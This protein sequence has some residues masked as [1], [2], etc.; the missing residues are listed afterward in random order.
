MCW[1]EINSIF[2]GKKFIFIPM[3]ESFVWLLVFW[4]LSPYLFRIENSLLS[5]K[6][7]KGAQ[8]WPTKYH[9]A[10]PW[11]DNQQSLL[12]DLYVLDNFC[13]PITFLVNSRSSSKTQPNCHLLYENVSTASRKTLGPSKTLIPLWPTSYFRSRWWLFCMSCLFS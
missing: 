1:I 9:S 10:L 2:T 13:D 11:K 6:S 7:T 4:K 3:N 5:R 8:L 12:L